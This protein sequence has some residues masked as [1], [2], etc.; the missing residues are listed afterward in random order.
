MFPTQIILSTGRLKLSGILKIV[1]TSKGR[2]KDFRV[3]TFHLLVSSSIKAKIIG[4]SSND[5]G[6]DIT[7]YVVGVGSHLLDPILD[8]GESWYIKCRDW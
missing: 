2:N 4:K 6:G 1:S 7:L 3:S 5:R 8:F